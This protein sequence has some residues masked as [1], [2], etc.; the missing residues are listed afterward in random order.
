MFAPGSGTPSQSRSVTELDRSL[1]PVKRIVSV[2]SS[3]G[4]MKFV[5]RSPPKPSVCVSDPST[6]STSSV[7]V[8]PVG[9]AVGV[10]VVGDAD[11]AYVATGDGR[12]LGAAVD[13][14]Q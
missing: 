7:S 3:P 8:S 5:D 4:F 10:Y 2:R 11:G 9:A 6:T 12:E 1:V 13:E 14:N